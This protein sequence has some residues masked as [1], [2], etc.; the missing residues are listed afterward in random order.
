MGA[1]ER[2]CGV[3]HPETAERKLTA[4]ELDPGCERRRRIGRGNCAASVCSAASSSPTRSWRRAPTRR[5][6]SAL[7]RSPSASS[8]CVAVSSAR[9]LAQV[10]RRERDLGLGDLAAGL[11]ES[12]SGAEAVRGAPQELARTL[13][14]AEL[15]HRDAAQSEPWRIVAG[16]RA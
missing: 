10:A 16:R 2:G 11:G 12:L 3:R 5:A 8:T 14:V 6:W 1:A 15:G 9:R 7:A 4:S 13:I